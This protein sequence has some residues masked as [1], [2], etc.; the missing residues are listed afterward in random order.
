[1]TAFVR[2]VM[3]RSNERASMHHVSGS[4]S[5]NTGVAPTYVTGAAD[6]IHVLSGTTTS[7]PGPTSSATSER[8]SALVHDGSAIAC[9]TPMCSANARSNR[10]WYMP[11][12]PYHAFVT[13]SVTYAIS[14]SLIQGPAT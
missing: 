10:S 12:L 7:S 2:G 14:F 1:M 13:A 9:A 6:A 8:C 3:Q 5:A 11:A 4:T